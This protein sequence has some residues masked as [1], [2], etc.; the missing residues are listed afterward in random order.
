MK[1]AQEN[2]SYARRTVKAIVQDRV[3]IVTGAGRGL[4][5]SHALDLAR[6]GA[7]VVVNDLGDDAHDVVNEIRLGGGIATAWV[8][9]VSNWEFAKSLIETSV[10]T[11]GGLHGLVNNAGLIRDRMLINMNE[12][13]WDLVVRI[14]LKG[15]FC[16]LR[17]AAAYWR[18]E[19]KRGQSVS[20]R[21]VNTTSGA[22]LQGSV[23]QSNYVAAKAG[24]ASLTVVAAAEL[25][26]YGVTVNAIAPAARTSMTA[27]VFADSM[28]K[29]AAGFDAMDPAN[30]SPLVTWLCSAES[31]DVSG[32]VFE[33]SGGSVSV[34]D[35]WQPGPHR[36][37]GSRWE[38]EDLGP[39]VHQLV[40]AAPPPAP[41]YG[42]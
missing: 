35:G 34:A 21:I 18:D 24:V 10:T 5:R 17:H 16:P 28:A 40:A 6:H 37:Q 11:F 23:G 4:G 19:A 27:D 1:P 12:E 13:E 38:A 30:V 36:D 29:P 3:I 20:A 41:V 32:R 42:V 9:D 15:H 14:D 8:G 39:V 25:A 7:K 22:G 31:V 2:V 26:R 33:V